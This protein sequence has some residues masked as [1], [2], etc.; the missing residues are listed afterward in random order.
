MSSK[1]QHGQFDNFRRTS[2]GPSRR[3]QSEK[4]RKREIWNELTHTI[5]FSLMVESC[6]QM[7][8]RENTDTHYKCFEESW[9]SLEAHT[10]NASL[11]QAYTAGESTLISYPCYSKWAR[12]KIGGD[13]R[14]R[15]AE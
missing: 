10:I 14:I 11:R 13:G 6:S 2:I 3:F 12:G 7:E 1:R 9:S 15:T 4:I 8:K 5:S